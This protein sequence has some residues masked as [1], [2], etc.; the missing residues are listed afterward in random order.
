MGVVLL[1]CHGFLLR[2]DCC[3]NSGWNYMVFTTTVRLL[4]YRIWAL[5]NYGPVIIIP[6]QIPDIDLTVST[7]GRSC[8]KNNQD[9]V[10]ILLPR[11]FVCVCV[12]GA[13]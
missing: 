2:N 4:T 3:G 9:T 12:C 7:S 8:P 10:E 6:I 11:L 1:F 5:I 13:S